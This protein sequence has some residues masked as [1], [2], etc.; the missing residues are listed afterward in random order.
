[1]NWRQTVLVGTLLVTGLGLLGCG[2][3]IAN[4]ATNPDPVVQVITYDE[5]RANDGDRSYSTMCEGCHK[6]GGLELSGNVTPILA[7][8]YGTESAI[9]ENRLAERTARTMPVNFPESCDYECGLNIQHSFYRYWTNQNLSSS[10]SSLNT[11]ASSSSQQSSSSS[12][13]GAI[14]EAE[15]QQRVANGLDLYESNN[16]AICHGESG[17]GNPEGTL[18]LTGT[19]RTYQSITFIIED[20][21]P[22]NMPPCSGE[23]CASQI[24]DYVWVEFLGGTLTESGGIR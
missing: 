8:V 12:S 17:Q 15:T 9:W 3:D 11:A 22:Q 24:A 10:S 23:N 6:A 1:M 20:G 19:E 21:V 18:S 2:E 13:S 7:T 14:S 5:Q 4:P 16:C